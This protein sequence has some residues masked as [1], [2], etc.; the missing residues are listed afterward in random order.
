[1]WVLIANSVALVSKDLPERLL[2]LGV[3]ALLGDRPRKGVPGDQ[4]VRV[5]AAQDPAAAV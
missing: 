3:A 5:A 2:R 4:G 1:M